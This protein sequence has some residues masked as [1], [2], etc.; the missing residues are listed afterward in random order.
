MPGQMGN[1]RV[2]Q[3]GLEVIE[4]DAKRNLLIVRGAVPGPRGSARGGA[5]CLSPSAQRVDRPG[6]RRSSRAALLRAVPRR[7]R[8]RGGARRAA[9]AP[10]GHGGDAGP[11]RGPWRRREAV[12]PEG[13]R[14]RPC[15]LD[16]RAA[17]DRRRRRLRPEPARLHGE[18]QPQGAHGGP[19]DRRSASTRAGQRLRSSTPRRSISL[20]PRPRSTRSSRIEGPDRVLVLV[21]GRGRRARCRSGTSRASRSCAAARPAS[22]TSSARPTLRRLRGR[23]RAARGGRGRRAAEEAA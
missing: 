2:T 5:Q 15:R 22:R 21:G 16:P 18:D 20:R 19:C 7:A 14:P 11:R 23:D 1:R 13:H 10:P 4:V 6:Q 3:R 8:L 9:R 12:A 17:L